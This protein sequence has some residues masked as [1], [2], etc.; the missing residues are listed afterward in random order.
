MGQSKSF[1]PRPARA[2]GYR[3]TPILRGRSAPHQK[4]DALTILT[5]PDGKPWKLDHFNHAFVDATR[6]AGL[7]GLSFHGLRKTAAA[8][9]A[10]A[11]ASANEIASITGHRPLGEVTR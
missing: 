7:T 1:K 10:E 5:R 3:N 4:C 9:L 6:A 8:W 11:G 2:Y